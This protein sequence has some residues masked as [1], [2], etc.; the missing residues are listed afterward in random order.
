MTNK[1]L[2]FHS[3]PASS[4]RWVVK[5][6]S[7]LLTSHGQGLN[8]DAIDSWVEQ[9][10]ELKKQGKEVVLVSSGS[11]AEG[12]SRLGWKSRPNELQKLQAAAAVGQMGLIQAYESSFQRF[13]MHTAQVLLTHEEIRNR[14]QYLNAKHTLKTLLELGVVPVINE[15]DTVTTDEIR[16][17]DNDNLA[18]M[19]ANL[20][21][22]DLLLILTDQQGVFDADPRRHQSAT[23]ISEISVNDPVL[24]L[25][26]GGA[27]SHIGSGGMQTKIEAARRAA[28]SGAM[29]IIAAGTDLNIIGNIAA[30]KKLGTRLIPDQEPLAAR[31][32]W[33]A[34]QLQI[35][36]KL[37]LDEG[38][39][40]ALQKAQGASLLAVGV[41]SVEGKF[42]RG[43]LVACVDSSGV[44]IARGLVNYNAQETARLIGKPSKD[45][46]SILGYVDELEL[47]HVDDLVLL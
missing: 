16:L 7:S 14:Q 6:G 26:A 17:G 45:I 38:G 20:V 4:Q 43:D 27:G 32:Q 9:L 34:G 3:D 15:N 44:E 42:R 19:V 8:C 24:D 5:I 36:G 41:V 18:A 29:T 37:M 33:L 25:V 31:K 30:N 23:L 2:K 35:R 22:A 21:E 12:M 39:V 1:T 10:V 40:S 46:E 13:S 47:I 28:R 11:V